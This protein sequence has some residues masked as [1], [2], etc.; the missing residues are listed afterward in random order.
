MSNLMDFA[1][2]ELKLLRGDEPCEM[3][4]EIEKCVLDI[5]ELFSKQGHSGTTAPYVVGILKKVMMYEPVAP[6]TGEDWEWNQVA[7]DCWQNKRCPHVFKDTPDGTAYDIE[8]VIFREPNGVCFTSRD[9]RRDVVFP[10]I[11]TH[12]YVEVEQ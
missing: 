8:A 7:D 1:R 3:Q 2:Q 9:S 6:L 5:V 4:D 10:Y 11:P 12:E